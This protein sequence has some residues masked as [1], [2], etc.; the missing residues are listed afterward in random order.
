VKGERHRKVPFFLASDLPQS[1]AGSLLQGI[2]AYASLVN[3]TKTCRSEPARDSGVSDE[4]DI[5]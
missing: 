1:R 5:D 2:E 4:K 3:D